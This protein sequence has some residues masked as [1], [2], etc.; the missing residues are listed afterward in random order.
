MS[1]RHVPVVW[2]LVLCNL[3]LFSKNYGL[4]KA[5]QEQFEFWYEDSNFLNTQGRVYRQYLGNRKLAGIEDNQVLG[6]L[7]FRDQNFLNLAH[8]NKWT[9]DQLAIKLWQSD[10][11]EF[12]LV[13]SFYPPMNLGMSESQSDFF[14]TLSY[15]FYHDGFMHLLG[16]LFLI[17]I[18]GGYLE[19]RHSG[20]LVFGT[21]LLSGS[22]SAMIYTYL[23]L[24]S[25]APLVGASGSL[26]GL[27]GLL[28]ALEFMKPTRLF[29]IILPHKD[30]MGFLQVPTLYWVLLFCMIDDVSGWLSHPEDLSGGVAYSVHIFGFG[31][32][33]FIGGVIRL[34]KASEE[35]PSL[36]LLPSR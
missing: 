32:G 36:P 27:I 30:Y 34:L 13:R 12:L 20:L 18:I 3:F 35:D 31:V 33:I 22:V 11:S 9:G 19:Q 7:A 1:F 6:R 26:C 16:N 29:Y 2:I 21:Y 23:G 24:G 15:Q 17:L 4:S 28:L 10:L 5:C 14:S 25:G 8:Q